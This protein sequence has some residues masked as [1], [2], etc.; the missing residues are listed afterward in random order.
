MEKLVK[1]ARSFS[2]KKNL[3]NFQTADFWMMQEVECKESEVEEKSEE[4]YKF[5]KSQV[6][7]AYNEYGT[8]TP[9]DTK[10]SPEDEYF[11]KDASKI[12]DSKGVFPKVWKPK[13]GEIQSIIDRKVTYEEPTHTAGG[14][15]EK[16]TR[17]RIK[18]QD[19]IP[20]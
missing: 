9:M 2:M 18:K 5:V 17:I 6:L 13:P 11:A 16:P 10:P 20:H 4:I 8:P 14:T 15:K 12:G 7:K 19:L 1:I 3:G